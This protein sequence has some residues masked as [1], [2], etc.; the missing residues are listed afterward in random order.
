MMGQINLYTGF[1]DGKHIGIFSESK[2]RLSNLAML[3]RPVIN[4]PR[5]NLPFFHG[6]KTEKP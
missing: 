1:E 2:E 3:L 6:Q 4:L 5:I